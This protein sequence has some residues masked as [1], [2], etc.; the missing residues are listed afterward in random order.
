MEFEIASSLLGF[1][2]TWI[3]KGLKKPYSQIKFIQLKGLLKGLQ[4]KWYFEGFPG[5]TKVTI[6]TQYKLDIPVFGK[7][8]EHLLLLKVRRTTRAILS[9]LK[10][11]SELAAEQSA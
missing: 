4:A 5:V 3:G 7:F 11:V 2:I 9:D 1:P 10:L 8:L 6:V